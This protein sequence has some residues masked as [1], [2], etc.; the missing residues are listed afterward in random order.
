MAAKRVFVTFD[1]DNHR[2]Y[3][4][5]LVSWNK[6]HA[7]EFREFYDASPA[8]HV[9]Q[10]ERRPHQAHNQNHMIQR[11]RHVLCIIGKNCAGRSRWVEWEVQTAARHDKNVAAVKVEDSCATPKLLIEGV[12]WAPTFTYEAI[13][14][15]IESAT[16]LCRR[17][18]RKPLALAGARTATPRAPLTPRQAVFHASGPPPDGLGA[19]LSSL[20]SDRRERGNALS[21]DSCGA[22][23]VVDDVQPDFIVPGNNQWASDAGLFHFDVTALL[24][25]LAIAKVLEYTDELVPRQR[26]QTRH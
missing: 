14:A 5:L 3:K 1:Y 22:D 10:H 17:W 23:Q 25:R 18:L 6:D 8:R 20:S 7:F 24:S 15:A 11:T 9:G 21:A 26:N 16:P 13:K 19:P 12:I 4:N 2:H